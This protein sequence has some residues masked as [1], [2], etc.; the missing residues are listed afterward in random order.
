MYGACEWDSGHENGVE[1]WRGSGRG[2]GVGKGNNL[3][4]VKGMEWS[5]TRLD[6]AR[7]V[8]VLQ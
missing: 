2:E 5:E 7:S 4:G 6:D 8:Y 1:G 3:N